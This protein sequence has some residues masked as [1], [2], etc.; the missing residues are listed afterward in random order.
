MD[1]LIVALLS[2]A[3]CF[4]ADKGFQKLFRGKVQHR[5]GLSVRASKYFAVAGIVIVVLA[6]VGLLTGISE[7]EWLLAAGSGLLLAVGIALN[8]YYLSFGL[9]YDEDSFVYSAFGRRSVT[10]HYR[11]IVG[12]QLYRSGAVVIIELH[13][14]DGNTVDL[15]SGMSGVYEFLDKAFA[16]WCL[17]KQMDP[18]GCP[19]HDPANSCWFPPVQEEE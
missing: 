13:L 1:I 14:S 2:F 10:Y 7:K 17:Q 5:S 4:A 9:F 6:A 12:Q 8:V 16:L 11:D 19:F 18:A 3:V 15:Q